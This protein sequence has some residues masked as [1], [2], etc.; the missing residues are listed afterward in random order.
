[1][2]DGYPSTLKCAE[3]WK[4]SRARCTPQHLVAPWVATVSTPNISSD[5]FQQL[6]IS[7]VWFKKYLVA[8]RGL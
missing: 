5:D 7:R 6:P 4:S 3:P 1:M 8:F 2:I